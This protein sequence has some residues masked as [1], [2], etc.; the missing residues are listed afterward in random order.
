MNDTLLAPSYGAGC[1]ICDFE[2]LDFAL[3]HFMRISRIELGSNLNV[4]FASLLLL[5]VIIES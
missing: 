4:V 5:T 1:W 3:C 2:L